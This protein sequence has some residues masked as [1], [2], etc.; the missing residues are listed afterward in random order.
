MVDEELT[1]PNDKNQKLINEGTA[2]SISNILNAGQKD[3]IDR[4]RTHIFRF[5]KE[6]FPGME[7][8]SEIAQF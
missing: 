4:F 1:K 5:I 6:E 8:P 7:E 3:E 2:L